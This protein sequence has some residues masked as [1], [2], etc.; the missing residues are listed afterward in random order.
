MGWG[1]AYRFSGN[2]RQH[3]D[4]LI[5]SETLLPRITSFR[6]RMVQNINIIQF[7]GASFPFLQA[8][9]GLTSS[10][11]LIG[12]FTGAFSLV[13]WDAAMGLRVPWSNTMG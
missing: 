10:L 12:L 13:L 5:V 1:N 7:T 2:W 4:T 6:S 8:G 3:L 9:S 11:M